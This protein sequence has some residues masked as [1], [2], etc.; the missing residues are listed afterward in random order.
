MA[1]KFYTVEFIG[2]PW[3]G[4]TTCQPKDSLPMNFEGRFIQPGGALHLYFL[5]A[6]PGGFRFVYQ[7]CRS[8]SCVGK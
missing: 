6:V 5:D 3:C 4:L 2:G 1:S 8:G 7:G